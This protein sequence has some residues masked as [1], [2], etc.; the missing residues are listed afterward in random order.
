MKGQVLKYRVGMY[1]AGS[2][3]YTVQN[4]Q[5]YKQMCNQSVTYTTGRLL[6]YNKVIIS[7]SFML[8]TV[9]PLGL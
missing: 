5:L 3:T 8:C 2:N 9:I 1:L 4:L 7:L 6:W